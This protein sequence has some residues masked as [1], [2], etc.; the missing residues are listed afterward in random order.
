M[1][2]RAVMN[3]HDWAKE[4]EELVEVI[5]PSMDGYVYFTALETGE[6]TRDKLFLGYTFKGAGTI[7]PRGY[8]L[9]YVG[10]GYTG[11]RGSPRILIVSLIDGSVLHTFGYNDSFAPRGWFA[12]DAAPL[13]DVEADRL[14][15]PSECGVIYI[16]DL[17]SS[18][19]P[20]S[21][22]VSISPSAPVKW[23]YKGLRSQAGGKYWLGIEASPVIWRGHLFFA[24][25]GGH[26]VC[27]D[28]NTLEPVWVRDVLDD[29]NC[30]PV[31]ELED[32]NPYIYISTGFHGGWRAPMNSKATVPIWKID[33]KTGE[34][35][36]QTEYDCYT[37]SGVSG[38][39]QGTAALGKDS[40]GDYIYVPVARTPTRSAGTLAALDKRTG[41]IA[42][43]FETSQYSW[44]SPV[45]VYGNDGKGY[46]IYTTAGGYMY[47]LDGLTGELYDS[48][49]LGGTLEA[50]P[51][52]Y[53]NTVVVGTRAMKIWGVTLT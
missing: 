35:V 51:A 53:G 41:D 23:R 48:V 18:F 39:V 14:I 21:G 17:C 46:I 20:V 49:S 4:R 1:E 40:L 5:Y 45:C 9:L 52:V 26:L 19:D 50:S 38:G 25:N 12:A 43:E 47:L 3:R 8:P 37:V 6:A 32:G 22:T 29:T 2:T 10:A 27:L 28:L 33:A 44:S 11:A 13:I 24:D 42:W 30:S 31:L 36:W 34:T 7:D 16:M 15:Y